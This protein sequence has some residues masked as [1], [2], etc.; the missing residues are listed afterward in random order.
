MPTFKLLSYDENRQV[1][2]PESKLVQQLNHRQHSGF[3]A[4]QQLGHAQLIGIAT[5][6]NTST[7]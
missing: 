7:S 4:G 5:N 1:V 3:L 2:V 6:D